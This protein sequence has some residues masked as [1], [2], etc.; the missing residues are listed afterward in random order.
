MSQ[1][2]DLDALR[3]A[4]RLAGFAWTDA[5]L[6]AIRPLVEASLRLLGGLDDLPLDD[7]E[8]TTQYRMF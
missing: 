3:G 6:E 8:P 5:Q 2:I 7:V 1:P 4:A